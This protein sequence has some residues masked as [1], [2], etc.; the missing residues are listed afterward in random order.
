[1]SNLVL[2]GIT[3]FITSITHLFISSKVVS[4]RVNVE[5]LGCG[6]WHIILVDKCSTKLSGM[7][8]NLFPNTHKPLDMHKSD[9]C[10]YLAIRWFTT[11]L[12]STEVSQSA[13]VWQSR[14]AY[15][16]LH[17]SFIP[18]KPWSISS[19]YPFKSRGCSLWTFS[20]MSC[21]ALPLHFLPSSELFHAI[22]SQR[23]YCLKKITRVWSKFANYLE[24]PRSVI[25]TFSKDVKQHYRLVL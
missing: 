9:M 2:Y 15:L 6:L 4:I 17:P 7:K 3:H 12:I 14:R 24:C 19:G 11:P 1:M 20:C 25:A 23:M 21:T 13:S 10:M 8:V 18:F 5:E 16:G 22:H